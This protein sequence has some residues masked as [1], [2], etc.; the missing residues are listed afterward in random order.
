MS[1]RLA[2]MQTGGE[3]ERENEA[4]ASPA[5]PGSQ[6]WGFLFVFKEGVVFFFLR[7]GGMEFDR[8][9]LL[10]SPWA[11]W[12]RR[13]PAWLRAAGDS[14]QLCPQ[15]PPGICGW[16][17]PGCERSERRHGTCP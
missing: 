15:A 7:E 1:L 6:P 2:A 3:N 17:R 8:R 4:D 9:W 11:P 14:G 13:G 10:E 12:T 16:Q 5:L